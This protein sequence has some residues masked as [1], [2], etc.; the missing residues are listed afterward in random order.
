MR[1]KLKDEAGFSLVEL[2]A[3]TV[4]LMLLGLMLNTGLQ[5][6]LNSYRTVVAQSEVELLLSTA[7]DALADDLRFAQDVT[8]TGDTVDS[9]FTYN[10]DSFGDEVRLAVDET[11]GQIMASGK[12]VLSTGVYGVKG[13]D[14]KRAYQ[15]AK[16]LITYNDNNTFTVYLKIESLADDSIFAETPNGGVQVRCL[17]PNDTTGGGT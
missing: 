5:M 12:R 14:G 3:V 11:T 4:V 8:K 16:M 13:A 10:S 7:V 15:V 2:L 6:A 9:N 1:K 17:N